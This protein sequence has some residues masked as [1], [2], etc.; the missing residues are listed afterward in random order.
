MKIP[1]LLAFGILLLLGCG[2]ALHS[3][4]WGNESDYA[5]AKDIIGPLNDARAKGRKCGDIYYEPAQ[6]LTW[7]DKLGRVALDHSM[8][9]AKTGYLNHKGSDNSDPGE[10]LSK[11]SYSWTSYGENVGQ[12][13]QTPEDAVENWLKSDLHCRNIMAPEFREAGAAYANNSTPGSFWTLIL[14]RPKK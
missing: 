9:M 10:R 5:L 8:D 4:S 11:A 12:G 14:G 3:A 2:S 1:Y 6:P 7:N 13:F